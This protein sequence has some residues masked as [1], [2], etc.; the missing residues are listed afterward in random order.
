MP[1][2]SSGSQSLG[3]MASRVAR[4]L[5][6]HQT[7]LVLAESCTCGLIAA[8]L[9]GIPGISKWLCGSAVVYQEAT[10]TAWLKVGEELISRH[11]VVSGEVAE[12]MALGALDATPQ[13]RLAGSITGHLGPNAPAP[14]DGLVFAAVARR[15]AEGLARIH[16]ARLKLPA[17]KGTP[18]A[19]RLRRREQAATFV[20]KLLHEALSKQR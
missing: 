10:K 3:R 2:S 15:D 14:L 8:S 1:R 9:G 16:M 6:T 12:A 5:A 11:G 17:G 7:P 20:L 18:Q 13:A 19:I 4:S